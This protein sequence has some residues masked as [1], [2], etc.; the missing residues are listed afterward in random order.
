[1]RKISHITNPRHPQIRRHAVG[2]S[3]V[4][5]SHEGVFEALLHLRRVILLLIKRHLLFR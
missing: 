3:A 4:V 1:M 2:S 5:L